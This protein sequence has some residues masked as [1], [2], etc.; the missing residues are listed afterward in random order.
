MALHQIPILLDCRC[1]LTQEGL[2]Y[3]SAQLKLG[4]RGLKDTRCQNR[5]LGPKGNTGCGLIN[6]VGLT[7]DRACASCW[8]TQSNDGIMGS[9]V[10][11]FS[12]DMSFIPNKTN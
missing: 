2:F 8:Q 3:T 5:A 6:C 10:L 11:F 9:N 7:A 4:Q 12:R 1:P